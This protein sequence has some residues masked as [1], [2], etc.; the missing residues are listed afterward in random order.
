MFKKTA[1]TIVKSHLWNLFI[2]TE[3]SLLFNFR[4][5]SGMKQIQYR[6]QIH[7]P[8]FWNFTKLSQ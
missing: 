4:M 5:P 8:E 3:I 2:I 7:L 1:E 6:I